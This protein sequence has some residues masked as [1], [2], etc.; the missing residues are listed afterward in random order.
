MEVSKKLAPASQRLFQFVE[1]DDDEELIGEVRKHPIGLLFIW[2][3]GIFSLLVI[4]ALTIFVSSQMGNELVN[5]D[6]SMQ[7]VVL[8]I[9]FLLS[10]LAVAITGIN[11]WLYTSDVLFITSEKIA[12][13]EYVSLF[14]RRVMQLNI[15]KVEDL[16]V[17]QNGILPHLFNYG[18]ILI[19]T[20]GETRNPAFTYLPDPN[21]VSKKILEAHESYVEKYG[22]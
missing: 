19:E 11:S 4:G 10:I 14:S 5:P 18:S 21:N 9:G 7:T 13:V 2:I 15:G 20:A 22:N 1:F 16:T 17:A 6:E 3:T 8:L 12:E